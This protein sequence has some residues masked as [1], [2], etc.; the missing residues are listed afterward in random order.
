MNLKSKKE[1]KEQILTPQKLANDRVSRFD[2][3]QG[4]KPLEFVPQGLS[5]IPAKAFSLVEA[6]IVLLI[7]TIALGMSAPMISRQLKNETMNNVQFQVLNKKYEE[8]KKVK[9]DIPSGAVM[10]FD[11]DGCPDGWTILTKFYPQAAGSFLRN[12]GEET[13]AG[14]EPRKKGSYQGSALPDIK[15]L[16]RVDGSTQNSYSVRYDEEYGSNDIG[17]AMGIPTGGT[18]EPM[19]DMLSAVK[20]KRAGDLIK[21]DI[22]NKDVNEVRPNNIAFLACRKN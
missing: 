2:A 15:L 20:N 18:D 5:L 6:M 8:L 12:L 17:G 11:L 7:G 9:S 10:Y 16:L 14:E 21:S 22:Y 3:P 1:R 4:L 13:L 19:Y